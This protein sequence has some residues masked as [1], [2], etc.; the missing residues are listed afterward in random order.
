MLSELTQSEIEEVLAD[1]YIGRIGCRDGDKIYI[2]PVNYIFEYGR[3]LCHS[4][5]GQKIA[6]MRRNPDVCFE[7][8]EIRSFNNWKTIVG[9]GV[10]EELT[11]DEDIEHA[12]S[13]LSDLM[14][15]QKASLTNAPP[16]EEIVKHPPTPA[17][18]MVYYRIRFNELSG[19]H[20][21]EI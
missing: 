4:Y 3:V 12:K 9:W 20:E 6:M 5:D 14:L 21:R 11:D 7:V 1:N 17:T 8:E 2:V 16:A 18:N 19:R 15:A 10:F 13:Q